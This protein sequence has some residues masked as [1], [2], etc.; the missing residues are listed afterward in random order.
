MPVM[1]LDLFREIIVE[2]LVRPNMPEM[3]VMKYQW[4]VSE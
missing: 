2:V 1:Q 3:Y 4:A